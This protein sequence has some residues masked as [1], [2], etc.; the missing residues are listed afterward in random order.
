MLIDHYRTL[1]QRGLVMPRTPDAKFCISAVCGDSIEPG[2]EG[3]ITSERL[4]L[5]D[6]CPE[7]VLDDLLGIRAVAGHA[8][9]Q[10]VGPI[11]VGSD[12][13]LGGPCLLPAPA[14]R[15]RSA[16]NSVAP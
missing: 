3:R 5:L 2:A 11:S 8:H 9:R 14:G 4:D 7:G 1:V 15:Q 16:N 10:A 13:G 6:H 12:Q